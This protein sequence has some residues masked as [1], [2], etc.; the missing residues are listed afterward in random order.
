MPANF[1]IISFQLNWGSGG[2]RPKLRRHRMCVEDDEL[3]EVGQI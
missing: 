1:M 3:L 2:R